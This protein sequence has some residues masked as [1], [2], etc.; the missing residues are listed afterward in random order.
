MKIIKVERCDVNRCCNC[1]YGYDYSRCC[2]V[3]RKLIPE[4]GKMING[5]PEQC[6]LEDADER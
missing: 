2:L 3:A 4:M 1:W 5:F 6:P